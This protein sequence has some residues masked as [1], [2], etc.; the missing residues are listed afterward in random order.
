MSLIFRSER[1][2]KDGKIFSMYKWR[3]LKTPKSGSNKPFAHL[4]EYTWCGRFL[5][6]YRLDETAQIVNIIKGDMRI[7]GPRPEENKTMK[8]VPLNIRKKIL[9]IRPG[10]FDIAGVYFFDEEEILKKAHDPAKV[11]FEVIKPMKLMLQ[12]FYVENRCILLDLA[13][14]WMGFKRAVREIWKKS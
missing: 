12:T 11:Y 4:N 2:G 14:I 9:S 7:V 1:V 8:L 6:K 3:T 5:R 13:I 10:W